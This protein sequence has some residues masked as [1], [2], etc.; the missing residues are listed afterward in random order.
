[1]ALQGPLPPGLQLG[2]G[3]D[4]REEHLEAL[5]LGNGRPGQ[6]DLWKAVF[7]DLAPRGPKPGRGRVG[8]HGPTA[9]LGRELKAPFPYQYAS[10]SEAPKQLL[11]RGAKE[12]GSCSQGLE[13]GLLCALGSAP[14]RPSSKV[15]GAV[16]R[17]FPSA[18]VPSIKRDWIRRRPSSAIVRCRLLDYARNANRNQRLNKDSKPRTRAGEV[19]RGE[20]STVV[21]FSLH[22]ASMEYSWNF[23]L[24]SQWSTVQAYVAA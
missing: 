2:V 1:L 14:G 4:G 15:K 17:L 22:L 13:H 23:H 10:L 9:G 8:D 7:G 12:G 18:A 24:L 5:A 3:G 6:A 20:I 16:G 21:L 11:L 19:T